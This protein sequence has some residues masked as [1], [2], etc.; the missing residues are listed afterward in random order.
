DFTNVSID[1]SSIHNNVASNIGVG[2]GGGV[3]FRSSIV[4]GATFDM[5]NSTVSGNTAR[6]DGG[7]LYFTGSSVTANI[8][9]STI[10]NNAAS[11]INGADGIHNLALATDVTVQ[12]S[13]LSNNDTRNCINVGVFG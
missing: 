5:N 4:G 12:D 2:G 1:S 11:S 13:I 6:Q 8:D 10:A 7:G 3:H 9:S